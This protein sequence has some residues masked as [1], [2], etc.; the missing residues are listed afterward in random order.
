MDDSPYIL[1]VEPGITIE[2]YQ[3]NSL[4]WLDASDMMLVLPGWEHSKGTK[5]EI[6]RAKE[7][8][9]EIIWVAEGQF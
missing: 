2:Q 5:A 7:R 1:R 3:K 4:A 8:G 9:M 6:A